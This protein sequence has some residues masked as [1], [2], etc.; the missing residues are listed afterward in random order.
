MWAKPSSPTGS[1]GGADESTSSAPA[2]PQSP[3]RAR[4]ES[5]AVRNPGR[6]F[7]QIVKL[8][9]EHVAEYEKCHAAVWPE[10]L[11]QIKA[12]NIQ[13]CE[14]SLFLLLALFT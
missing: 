9:P 14:P 8:K 2:E 5:T 13:D 3:A 7:A 10:V 12:C 1:A 11:Q 4:R 6:R